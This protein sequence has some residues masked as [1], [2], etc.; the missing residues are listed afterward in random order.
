LRALGQHIILKANEALASAEIRRAE[1]LAS[2]EAG[3][4]TKKPRPVKK[5][6]LNLKGNIVCARTL[7][8]RLDD[9]EGLA[10]LLAPKGKK[11]EGWRLSPGILGSPNWP[12]VVWGI[13]EDSRLLLGVWDNGLT[14]LQEIRRRDPLMSTR[15]DFQ[16]DGVSEIRIQVRV[17]TL[18]T[19]IKRHHANKGKPMM[20]GS[21]AT[22]MRPGPK[23]KKAGIPIQNGILPSTPMG[24]QGKGR[25]RP[26]GPPKPPKE[27]GPRGRAPRKQS[28]GQGQGQNGPSTPQTPESPRMNISDEEDLLQSEFPELGMKKLRVSMERMSKELEAKYLPFID[29]D[30]ESPR[31]VSIPE[32]LEVIELPEEK[33]EEVI[34]VE[35]EDDLEILEV[36]PVTDPLLTIKPIIL[37]SSDEDEDDLN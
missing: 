14:N 22:P 20:N 37:I 24:N 16:E 29:L 8:N 3:L 28:F 25:G 30:P 19:A 7:L 26:A 2:F 23:S 21:G 11:I 18:L 15:I 5:V 33:Q 36:P 9:W 35:D 17:Q 1:R 13:E 10:K 27:K 31:S 32:C 6:S 4:I 12:N 34:E